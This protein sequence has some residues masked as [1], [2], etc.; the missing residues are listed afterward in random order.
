MIRKHE[1][2][3]RAHIRS[4]LVLCLSCGLASARSA[5]SAVWAP[6]RSS[7]YSG[8]CHFH[9]REESKGGDETEQWVLKWLLTPGSGHPIHDPLARTGV[10]G[11]G[12]SRF[13]QGREPSGGS[14]FR[15]AGERCGEVLQSVREKRAVTVTV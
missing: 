3:T 14:S 9:R 6:G 2:V 15:E 1:W 4:L 13:P 11:E 12:Q 8:T 7:P 5:P 10:P